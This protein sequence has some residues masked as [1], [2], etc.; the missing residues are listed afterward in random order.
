MAD[1]P[2]D[3]PVQ[4][5]WCPQ[6]Y[7]IRD[8]QP[9]HLLP[10]KFAATFEWY[11]PHLPWANNPSCLPSSSKCLARICSGAPEMFF[12][13]VGIGQ[14]LRGAQGAG[15]LGQQSRAEDIHLLAWGR[16]RLT[17]PNDTAAASRAISHL[18]G[19]VLPT[20]IQGGEGATALL[21]RQEEHNC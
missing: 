6:R 21:L 9:Q 1:I 10:P 5:W 17:C 3:S 2:T 20:C 18:L 11:Q 14:V 7:C 16:R 19:S 15:L 12:V 4:R 13:W 8:L